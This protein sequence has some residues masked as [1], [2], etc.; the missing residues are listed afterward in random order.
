MNDLGYTKQNKTGL[1][2]LKS[3]LDLKLDIYCVN[4]YLHKKRNQ[5]YA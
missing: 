3:C 1:E 2:F 5:R 4:D